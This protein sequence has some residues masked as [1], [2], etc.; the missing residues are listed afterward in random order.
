MK[1]TNSTIV[2]KTS[3]EMK[4][5]L[6]DEYHEKQNAKRVKVLKSADSETESDEPDPQGGQKHTAGEG[7]YQISIEDAVQ[8][9][10]LG[11]YGADFSALPGKIFDEVKEI[12]KELEHTMLEKPIRRELACK[13][14]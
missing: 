10:A 8:T 13:S 7:R 5:A 2:K 1:S 14:M 9:V 3:K 6:L 11:D 4:K 12:E